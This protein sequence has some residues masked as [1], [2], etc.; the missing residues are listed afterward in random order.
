[1]RESQSRMNPEEMRKA[2]TA[3]AAQ[4]PM[5]ALELQRGWLESRENLLDLEFRI[6]VLYIQYLHESS[7]L[8]SLPE[9]NYL[10]KS[11]KRIL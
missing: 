7:L 10:S 1:M 6:R 2:S 3:I 9:S 5:L 8:A 11:N 4:D